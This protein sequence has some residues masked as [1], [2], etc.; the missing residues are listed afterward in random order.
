[1]D[2]ERLPNG[3]TPLWWSWLPEGTVT[4]SHAETGE[5]RSMDHGPRYC[6]EGPDRLDGGESRSGAPANGTRTRHATAAGT[7][8]AK[9]G[10]RQAQETAAAVLEQARFEAARIREQATEDAEQLTRAALDQAAA[11]AREEAE[12]RGAEALAEAARTKEALLRQSREQAFYEG[13]RLREEAAVQARQIV[14]DAEDEARALLARA[15]DEV[16]RLRTQA[17]SEAERIKSAILEHARETAESEAVRLREE[18][19]REAEEVKATIVDLARKEAE[20]IRSEAEQEKLTILE[21]AEDEAVRLH[22]EA[23]AHAGTVP[24]GDHEVKLLRATEVGSREFPE[25]RRGF[26]PQ[27]VTK[28]L[29]VVQTSYSI[30]EEELHRARREW[31]RTMEVLETMRVRLGTVA[32]GHSMQALL[33]QHLEPARAAWADSVEAL[34]ARHPHLN[35]YDLPSL[36]VRAAQLETRLEKRLYGYS[37]SQVQHLL[38]TLTTELARLENQVGVLRAENDELRGRLL[39][40]VATPA[41]ERLT[42]ADV[43]PLRSLPFKLAPDGCSSSNGSHPSPSSTDGSHTGPSA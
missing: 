18:A 36:L 16:G 43:A 37:S 7:A 38:E 6:A 28:W 23:A 13:T 5:H 33:E 24:S 12:R 29:K 14:A 19:V 34:A 35:D 25:V 20:R 8:E 9:D 30:L 10:L 31:E 27:S 11:Q 4:M 21:Q 32:G 15:G 42:V 17:I 22:L 39:A 3:F 26:D 40:H 1:M 41:P 2:K